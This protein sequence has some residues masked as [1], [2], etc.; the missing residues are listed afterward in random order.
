M[1]ILQAAVWQPN[2]L[3]TVNNMPSLCLLLPP[4]VAAAAAAV[5]EAPFQHMLSGPDWS[6]GLVNR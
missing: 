3:M 4:A 2:P 6:L 1:H 5:A